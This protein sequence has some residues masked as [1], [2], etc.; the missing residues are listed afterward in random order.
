MEDR[1]IRGHLARQLCRDLAV[2]NVSQSQLAEK[3]GVGPSAISYHAKKNAEEIAAI[4]ADIENE[5]AGMW[6]AQKQSRVAEYQSDA[7]RIN[8]ALDKSD[9][10][11]PKLLRAKNA[12][13][14]AAAEE[15]GQLS[16]KVQV[17]VQTQQVD[18]WIDGC[19][20]DLI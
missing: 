16:A 5:F 4:K 8:T 2:G 3:Y 15:M 17:Q 19:D 20:L 11:D 13:L 14:K 9:E 10:L 6:I 1:P 7:E 18:Y 12:A